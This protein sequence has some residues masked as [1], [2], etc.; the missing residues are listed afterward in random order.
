MCGLNLGG[1]P[2]LSCTI[3][4]GAGT[5]G[6]CSCR[7]KSTFD[8]RRL[9]DGCRCWRAKEPVGEL[10]SARPLASNNMVDRRHQKLYHKWNVR[11]DGS[12]CSPA[13]I[14]AVAC[15]DME[16]EREGEPDGDSARPFD[17]MATGSCRSGVNAWPALLES[18]FFSLLP[19]FLPRGMEQ[20]WRRI[21]FAR[22]N[23]AIW[24]ETL[25]VYEWWQCMSFNQ[26]MMVGR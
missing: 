17:A 7:F 1:W 12:C 21:K 9:A 18:L 22:G 24:D 20:F 10:L 2:A 5:D 3:S 23:W 11:G 26:V 16:A 15:R 25:A 13:F 14:V 19:F 8:L 6:S 4:P